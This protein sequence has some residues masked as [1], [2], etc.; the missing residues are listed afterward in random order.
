MKTTH[1]TTASMYWT[2]LS[3]LSR[4][5]GISW[6]PF[7]L[8]AAIR[9]SVDV[10]AA[11]AGSSDIFSVDSI[12]LFL[13]P[14]STADSNE[15]LRIGGNNSGVQL[16]LWTSELELSTVKI[17]AVELVSESAG[18]SY[19]YWFR[20]PLCRLGGSSTR[21]LALPWY[22][23]DEGVKTSWGWTVHS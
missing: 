9:A 16:S 17:L 2:L 7:P 18:L 10:P 23:L 8:S 19:E 6:D 5:S 1:P 15:D 14:V 3:Q 11:F 4:S 12:Q 21:D 20:R 22:I 13:L